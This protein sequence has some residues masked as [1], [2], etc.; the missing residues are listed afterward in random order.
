MQYLISV[1]ERYEYKKEK[2]NF[3]LERQ[4]ASGVFVEMVENFKGC[5][6][7]STISDSEHSH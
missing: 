1:S 7:Q 5:T 3:S 2:C 4:L 6:I